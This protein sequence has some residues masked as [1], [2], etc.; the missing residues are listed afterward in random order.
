MRNSKIKIFYNDRQVLK[1]LANSNYSKSPLKPKLVIN[2][3]FINDLQDHFEI[4]RNF[5][6]FNENDFLVAHTPHYVHSVFRGLT[7]AT[8]NHL[9]WSPQFADSVRFTNASLYSAIRQ[10]IISRG[11]DICFSPTSGFHH[12]H[13]GYGSGFCTF[14]GQVIASTKIYREFG[15]S[16][17]YVDLDGHFGNSIEDARE[18][19]HDLKYSIPL[20]CNINPVGKNEAYFRNFVLKLKG[21]ENKIMNDE[22]HYIVWCH[23]ADSHEW[24]QLGG[25][26]NTEYWM[27]CATTFWQ[28]V[29]EM[30]ERLGRP[31][32]VSMSL[33]GGYRDDDYDSVLNLHVADL[34]ECLNNLL[35]KDVRFNLVVKPP[36]VKK[37]Q[38]SGWMDAFDK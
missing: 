7:K 6:P 3:L 20:G 10:S 15:L 23:G 34:V 33:F 30:D 18:Y 19:V 13:P 4:V 27:Q 25:Q 1:V 37:T 16:G 14:S 36:P 12:A 32:P 38:Y 21:L 22:V 8:T 28:W 17:A 35:E 9:E 5:R 26:V 11:K 2:K 24:D 29:Q 31:L